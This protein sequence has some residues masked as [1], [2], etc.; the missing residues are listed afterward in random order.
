M[1]DTTPPDAPGPPE[2]SPWIDQREAC[3]LLGTKLP[4]FHYWVRQGQITTGR[5]APKPG[6]GKYRLYARDE[7]ERLAG[8]IRER[9]QRRVTGELPEGY[10]GRDAAAKM[11]GISRAT[12]KS[13]VRQ[14]KVPPGKIIS[15][16]RGGRRGVY[17]L[18]ELHRIR[19]EMK[20]P[21]PTRPYRDPEQPG[22]YVLP[23]GMVR[24]E[25]A[26]CQ[27]G[28]TKRTWER[29]ERE[30]LI[31]CGEMLY[32]AGGGR[33]KVYPL[34]ELK[35][36]L[37]AFGRYTPP[38]PDPD[39]PGCVRVPL[40]GKGINRREAIIDAA[41][42]PLLE[43][44]TCSCAGGGKGGRVDVYVSFHPPGGNSVPL[45]RLIMAATGRDQQVGHLNDDPLDCRRQNLIVRTSAQRCYTSRKRETTRGLPPSSRYKGVLWD[46]YARRW[47]AGIKCNGVQRWLGRFRDEVAAAE[48]YDEAARELFGEHA[49]LNFPDGVDARVA[50]EGDSR[51]AA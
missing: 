46:S 34:T 25:D 39:R 12:W 9:R 41:D 49:W 33:L 23:A 5:W 17:T 13:W 29:W 21:D 37:A 7:I 51:A 47:R 28:V 31:N 30:G 22:A 10:V 19:E 44:G 26:W 45:R 20:T 27:F 50:E 35:R 18:D 32:V 6:G 36:L 3:R 48:A 42:L 43:A 1:A 11:F 16:L 4:M 24:R 15:G 40:T 2:L 14:R 8:T 38:Y